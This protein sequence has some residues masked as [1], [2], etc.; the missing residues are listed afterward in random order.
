[1]GA[2]A[3]VGVIA[4]LAACGGDAAQCPLEDAGS[5]SGD[6]SNADEGSGAILVHGTFTNTTCPALYPAGA[7]PDNGGL[8]ELTATLSGSPPDGG[9][10]TV[11][12]SA[13]NG[14]FVNPHILDTTFQ[15]VA[16]GLVTLT[17]TVS[18]GDCHQQESLQIDCNVLT[19][20]GN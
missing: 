9:T 3:A 13:T 6:S 5:E 19:G 14:I 15:C 8:V 10:P 20:G 11:V 18:I 7:S 17:L 2:C 1:V 12:W 16:I 4:A